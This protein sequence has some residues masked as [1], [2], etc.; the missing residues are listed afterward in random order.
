[1]LN[2]PCL[3]GEGKKKNLHTPGMLSFKV[4]LNSIC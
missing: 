2:F 4:Q 1:M 3:L